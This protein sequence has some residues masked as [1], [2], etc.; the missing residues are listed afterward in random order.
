M[1]A[2]APEGSFEF[3]TSAAP[4]KAGQAAPPDE[5]VWLEGMPGVRSFTIDGTD[6]VAIPV[7][8]ITDF[9]PVTEI[10]GG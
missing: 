6:W 3:Y 5:A 8:T 9:V 10:P 7:T 4:T 2:N 1:P